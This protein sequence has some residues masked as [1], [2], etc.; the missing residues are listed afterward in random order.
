MQ[1]N[2]PKRVTIALPIYK[3]LEYLPHV[4]RIVA[5]EDY[6]DIE[7]IVSDNGMNG[8]RVRDIVEAC[9]PRPH[10][11]RQN[12]ATVNISQHFNQLIDEA[13]GEYFVILCDDDEI[14]SNY[15][16][17][18]VASLEMYPGASVAIARQEML[19]TNG[20]VVRRS[21]EAMPPVLSGED[22]I[23]ATWRDYAYGMEMV[24]T[25]L[26]RTER[27]RGCGGYPDFCRGTG[28]DNSLLLKLVL[29]GSVGLNSRC[30]FRWRLDDASFG[31]SVSAAEL[32]RASREFLHFLDADPVIR[33]YAM[34]RPEQWRWIK[35]SLVE[36]TWQT[37]LGRWHEIYRERLSWLPWVKSAF[38]MPLIADYYKMIARHLYADAK[39]LLKRRMLYGRTPP[40]ANESPRI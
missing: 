5:A 25:F 15:V 17:E 27:L 24:G 14:S 39:S 6:P 38:A 16:S 11:F 28:I 3:R 22:F 26:A 8:T 29:G 23:S 32:A 35:G 12:P 18:L 36:M 19:A 37:Y 2:V 40:C 13:T 21:S 20:A 9:Y 7:L 31:W 34:A 30:A 1:T 4:L 33:E 10:R